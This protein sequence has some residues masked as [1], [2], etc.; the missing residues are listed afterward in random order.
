MLVA[1]RVEATRR[2]VGSVFEAARFSFDENTVRDLS[3]NLIA[4]LSNIEL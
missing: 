2:V 1:R 4:N 3:E